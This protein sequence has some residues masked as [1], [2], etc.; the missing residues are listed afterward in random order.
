VVALF[1][2]VVAFPFIAFDDAE[3]IVRNPQITAPL[4]AP[5]DLLLTPHVGYVVPVT[6]AF[7]AALFALAHGAPLAFHAAALGLHALLASQLLSFA[8]RL[9]LC[10]PFAFAAALVF[11][12]H[13]LVL[14]PVAWAICLKD[15]LMANLALAST[16][17]FVAAGE[18]EGHSG[19]AVRAVLLALLAML[20]KPSA[21]LIGFA[22]LAHLIARRAHGGAPAPALRA[23][24]ATSALG[25]LLGAASRFSHNALLGA[26]G[27]AGW[28]PL[29]PLIVLGR[30]LTHVVWPVD[31]LVLYPDPSDERAPLPA[32]AA[33]VL[34][35][36]GIA[37]L[38]RRVR[39]SP[40]ALLLVAL[41][42]AIYLPTSD[43]LPFAR[44]MS[45][46]Y[47]YLPLACLCVGGA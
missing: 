3:L 20:S 2:P 9:G 26:N 10:L 15:L 47:M 34:G 6:I 12:V 39:N 17:A 31:L 45:D 44:V 18:R 42:L 22:W 1:A 38:T 32:I 35:V 27:D 14:Q 33:G 46:S 43:L 11:A 13:P 23:A 28:T 36:L 4:A 16:R 37:L 21:S 19:Q 40:A 24:L 41:A 7:E 30:Q 29:A 25:T 8:R 5:L